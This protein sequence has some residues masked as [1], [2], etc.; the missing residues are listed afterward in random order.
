[1]LIQSSYPKMQST[2]E[3]HSDLLDTAILG[4]DFWMQ[5]GTNQDSKP[6]SWFVNQCSGYK[7]I[8][9]IKGLPRG[10]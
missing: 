1:M 2:I 10:E 5:T 8:C 9:Y 3:A 4:K 6:A 7:L